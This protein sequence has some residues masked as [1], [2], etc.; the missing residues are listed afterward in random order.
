MTRQLST[1]D[2]E[3]DPQN[4]DVSAEAGP[5]PEMVATMPSP[6]PSTIPPGELIGMPDV[7]GVLGP[8]PQVPMPQPPMPPSGQMDARQQLLHAIAAGVMLGMGP[9]NGMAAGIGEGVGRADALS[10][11]QQQQQF[12]FKQQQFLREQQAALGQQRA[13]DAAQ[14]RKDQQL[15]MT[16]LAFKKDMAGITSE[17]DYDAL[18]Q[19]YTGILQASGF[20]RITPLWF[21]QN[22]KFT[23]PSDKKALQMAFDKGQKA[24]KANGGTAEMFMRSELHYESPTTGQEVRMKV[25]EAQAI[26]GLEYETDADGNLIGMQ[27]GEGK[28]YADAR[29]MAMQEYTAKFGH[30]PGRGDKTANDYIT[31]RIGDIMTAASKPPNGSDFDAIV[32][33]KEAELGRKLTSGELVSLKQSL[34]PTLSVPVVISTPNGPQIV[35]RG[36]GTAKPITGADGEPVQGRES[37]GQEKASLA[38]YNRAKEAEDTLTGGGDDSLED[39]IAKSGLM[40]QGRLAMAPNFLQSSEQQVYRQAQRAFTEARL[41]KESGANITASEYANDA[42]TLFAQP[43]DLPEVVK[44]KRAARQRVLDGLKVGAGRAVSEYYGKGAVAPTAPTSKTR[45]IE[46]GGVTVTVTD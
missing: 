41:R 42:R 38:F 39:R 32:A 11:Q 15:K 7:S 13:M 28:P 1:T 18:V 27:A 23:P 12:A 19:Q 6:G 45:T 9:R 34:S 29:N 8:R 2:L 25:R 16:L 33:T 40:Q 26:L 43:G 31:K 14:D 37:S 20:P 24:N 17:K 36:T 35:N 46:V 44:K 4:L 5:L 21:Y 22:L 10:R 3:A 30:P